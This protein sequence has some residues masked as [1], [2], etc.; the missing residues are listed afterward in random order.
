MS[1]E[2]G[3]L[4]CKPFLRWLRA[5]PPVWAPDVVSVSGQIYLN[6]LWCVTACCYREQNNCQS[7][8]QVWLTYIYYATTS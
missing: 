1:R 3:H 7:T 2:K 8:F 5:C 4:E 6:L